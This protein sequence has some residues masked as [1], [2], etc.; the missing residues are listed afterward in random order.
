LG[1]LYTG[2]AG[3]VSLASAVQTT[4][5][6]D[7]DADNAAT[8]TVGMQK[9]DDYLE[10]L[11]VSKYKWLPFAGLPGNAASTSYYLAPTSF[12]VAASPTSTSI[13]VTEHLILEAC[14]LVL[15][16][17]RTSTTTVGGSILLEASINEGASTVALRTLTAGT[18]A[19]FYTGTG[20]LPF[21]LN[22]GDRLAFQIFNSVGVSTGLGQV[23]AM[24][25]V[26]N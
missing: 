5:P 19:G 10:A 8:F 21:S 12:S 13:G 4:V 7:G 24:M 20:A 23:I 6:A 26:L 9:A 16:G 17:I 18:V 11:R 3:N 14:T 25:A 2:V 22:A 1:T 15:T